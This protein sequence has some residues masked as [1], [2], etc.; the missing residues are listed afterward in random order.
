M[1]E[2]VELSKKYGPHKAIDRISFS[3]KKGE[4]VGFLGPNGAGKTT[5]M[6]IIT[7]FMPPTSGVAKVAGFDVFENPI[8]VKKRIGY[9]PETPPVY[10]EMTVEEYLRFVARLKGVEKPQITKMVQRAI[11]KTQLGEVQKRLIQ[12]LSKGYRQRVG[13]SQALVSDPDVLVLDEPTVGLD[14]RQVAEVRDLIKELKGH[15]TI[16]LSTHILPEVQ[17]TCERI[18]IINRGRIVAEDSLENIGRRMQST[19]RVI[20]RVGTPSEKLKMDLSA[21]KG[22]GAVALKEGNRFEIDTD[23][24]QGLAQAVASAVVNSGAGLVEMREETI[25]LE[26][27]FLKLTTSEEKQMVEGATL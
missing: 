12:N 21:I 24:T 20:V 18:I 1:I 4:V 17:A 16:I 14:P 9:L 13:I 15:H 5:T 19:N 25:N 8:E 2:V 22:V 7:G 26:D 27:V 6:R 3:V 11:E 23:G 10:G